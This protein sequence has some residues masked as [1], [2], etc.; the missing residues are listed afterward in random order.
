MADYALQFSSNYKTLKVIDIATSIEEA[1]YPLDTGTGSV[2]V[3]VSGTSYSVS[4]AADFT[5]PTHTLD[6]GAGATL[7]FNGARMGGIGVVDLRD[8]AKQ[9]EPEL[10]EYDYAL[11]CTTFRLKYVTGP[12]AFKIAFD[13]DEDCYDYSPA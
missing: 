1:S 6:V 12:F 3:A 11:D 7:S 4:T 10:L 2:S 13:G 8:I 5:T 9:E